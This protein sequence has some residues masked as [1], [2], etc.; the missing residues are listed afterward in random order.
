MFIRKK[1]KTGKDHIQRIG[2]KIVLDFP[3]PKNEGN[4]IMPFL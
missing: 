2:N 4:E 3:Y 1:T